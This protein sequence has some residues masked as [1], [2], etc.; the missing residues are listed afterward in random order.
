MLGWLAS[1]DRL[2]LYYIFTSF[3]LWIE[4]RLPRHSHSVPVSR[5]YDLQG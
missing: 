5:L 3:R 2:V 4:S 1:A